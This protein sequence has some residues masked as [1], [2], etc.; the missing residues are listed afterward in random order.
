MSG[1]LY[2]V[3]P[4]YCSPLDDIN[5]EAIKQMRSGHADTAEKLWRQIVDSPDATPIDKHD[6]KNNLAVLFRNIG[7]DKEADALELEIGEKKLAPPDSE[8]LKGQA[9]KTVETHF[10]PLEPVDNPAARHTIDQIKQKVITDIIKPGITVADTSLG[11]LFR[12]PG[13]RRALICFDV[14]VVDH[15][16][17][18][19][20]LSYSITVNDHGNGDIEILSKQCA[21]GP[22]ELTDAGKRD[23]AHYAAEM[24]A[25]SA[26]NEAKLAEEA[27][28]KQEAAQAA[29]AQAPGQTQSGGTAATA[30]GGTSA[31]GQAGVAANADG[32]ATMAQTQAYLYMLQRYRNY[33]GNR[34]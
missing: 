19:E 16:T 6:A 12:L 31:N 20:E 4:V 1:F 27:A 15:E 29:S 10:S 8:V 17:H 34:K 3:N 26:A 7:R 13:E 21:E 32:T 25:K 5:V 9:K 30:S 33:A 24:E 22:I 2:C 14:K 11:V 18:Q 23:A 28:R